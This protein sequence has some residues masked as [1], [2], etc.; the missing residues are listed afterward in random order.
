MLCFDSGRSKVIEGCLPEK[1]VTDARDHRY[2]SSAP[3][4]CKGLIR[5]FPSE[6]EM[7]V[8]SEDRFARARKSIGEG[9][10]VYVGTSHHNDARRTAHSLLSQGNSERV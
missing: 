1:V 3:A 9:G 4:R 10:E 2:F 8:F 5:T 6:A 7:K